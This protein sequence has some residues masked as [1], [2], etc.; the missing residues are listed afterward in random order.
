MCI[1]L[2]LT[3]VAAQNKRFRLV[4]DVLNDINEIRN[5]R[6]ERIIV[7]E[8][9]NLFV[10]ITWPPDVKGRLNIWIYKPET[11]NTNLVG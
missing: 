3:F 2:M 9:V 1:I 6:E 5:L 7:G 4:L 10:I 11:L 8:S